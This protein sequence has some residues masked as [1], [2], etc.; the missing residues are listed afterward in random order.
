MKPMEL[1]GRWL[2]RQAPEHRR[3]MAHRCSRAL[4]TTSADRD[5]YL[6]VSLVS[7]HVGKE[8]LALCATWTAGRVGKP[9]A[10][11][12]RRDWTRRSGCA[13]IPAAV[14]ARPM[15]PR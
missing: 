2:A 14:L 1:L 15:A 12:I 5:I 4:R 6:L 8:P 11:G 3:S 13:R 7:R 9:P 10:A